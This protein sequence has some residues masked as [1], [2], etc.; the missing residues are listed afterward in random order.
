MH[1]LGY[2]R[3]S[4]H[5]GIVIVVLLSAN[6]QAGG[7]FAPKAFI[8][9]PQQSA[10]YHRSTSNNLYKA[11]LRPALEGRQ[12]PADRT[13]NQWITAPADAFRSTTPQPPRLRF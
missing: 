11:A 3:T 8:T 12:E 13:S 4:V 7:V 10:T 2:T 6:A 1:R 5:L 9:A